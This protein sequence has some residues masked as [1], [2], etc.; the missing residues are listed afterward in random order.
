MLSLKHNFLFVHI[1][2]TA[3][4][5]IQTVLHGYSEDEIVKTQPWQDGVERFQV[6]SRS[7]E[8]EKHSPLKDYRRELGDELFQRLFKF[9][10]VRNPWDR[11]ISFFFSP[12]RGDVRWDRKKFKKFLKELEPTGNYLALNRGAQNTPV[13]ENVDYVMRYETLQD[14]FRAVCDRIGI[15]PT[16][17][18]VRN[19]SSRDH[20]ARYYD[21]Y[22]IEFVR[23]RFREEI[24]YFGY[25]FELQPKS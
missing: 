17:L 16:D 20:Y 2:K 10:C 11:A 9:T 5:A 1:P 8:L 19:K 22:L 23:S 15:P 4:N 24:E 7:Y 14:D 12:H 25:E 3:G 18:P 13:F 6:R 21:D